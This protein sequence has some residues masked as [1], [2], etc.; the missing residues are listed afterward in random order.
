MVEGQHTVVINAIAFGKPNDIRSM[1]VCGRGQNTP[2]LKLRRVMELSTVIMLVAAAA[3][4]AF[5]NAIAG[6]GSLLTLPAL[7]W[8]GVPAASAN[9]TGAAALLA[10]YAASVLADAR[11]GSFGTGLPSL[12]LLFAASLGALGGGLVLAG[13]SER[14]FVWLIP[15]LI[16][17]ATLLF[18]F[19]ASLEAFA[20]GTRLRNKGTSLTAL[21]LVGA[22]GGYFNGGLGIL[23]LS[24][25]LMFE[26]KDLATANRLKNLLSAALTLVGAAT[27]AFAGLI[28]WEYLPLMA[29]AAFVFGWL[30]AR[31]AF[32]APVV[33]V[34]QIIIAAGLI[35]TFVF[36]HQAIA[37]AGA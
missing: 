20:R 6:G 35:L 13:S 1:I 23:L 25:L 30:G 5:V 18:A 32:R 27:Y 29:P 37:G 24:H 11:P 19:S 34:R 17:F 3:A 10:G 22:Y 4:A 15:V 26:T 8:A 9:A 7:I 28:R 21:A 16:G 14:F 31:W 2:H 12:P 33:I 36:A